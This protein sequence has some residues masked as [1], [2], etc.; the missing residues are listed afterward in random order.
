[1]FLVA[2]IVYLSVSNN[3]KS[4]EQIL[5]KIS[6]YLG[7]DTRSDRLN[8]GGYLDHHADCPIGYPAITPQIRSEFWWNFQDNSSTVQ[9]IIA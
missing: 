7:N 6:R 2:F 4:Y 9:G 8:Y 3:S 1:M 5:M